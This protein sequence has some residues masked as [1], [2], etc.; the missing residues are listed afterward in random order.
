[1]GLCGSKVNSGKGEPKPV[2]VVEG[3]SVVQGEPLV[4]WLLRTAANHS[5]AAA[6]GGPLTSSQICFIVTLD[7]YTAVDPVRLSKGYREGEQCHL[8]IDAVTMTLDPLI[9]Q[10]HLYTHS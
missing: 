4:H 8:T 5:S 1:M 7:V 10:R 9:F 2:S 3:G 6:A